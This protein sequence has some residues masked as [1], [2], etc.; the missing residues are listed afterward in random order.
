MTVIGKASGMLAIRRG[1]SFR[2]PEAIPVITVPKYL[3]TSIKSH[4]AEMNVR[5]DKIYRQ[6]ASQGNRNIP[7]IT[8]SKNMKLNHFYGQTYPKG[9]R[10]QESIPLISAGWKRMKYRNDEI[11]FKAYADNPYFNEEKIKN[12]SSQVNSFA[13]LGLSD[14]ACAAIKELRLTKPTYIQEQAIPEILTSK[15][16]ICTADT[17]SGK[18]IAYLA[19]LIQMIKRRKVNLSPEEHVAGKAPYALIVVP[20]REL[21]EQVGNIALKIGKI[22]GVGVATMIGGAPKYLTHTGYDIVVTTIGL[23]NNHVKNRK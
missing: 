7:V 10:G 4:R 1:F 6:R 20:S 15:N 16:I 18:T 12:T 23:I 14:E 8:S 11:T 17:G 9:H 19:P 3:E 21:A 5:V 13:E 22:C 2:P